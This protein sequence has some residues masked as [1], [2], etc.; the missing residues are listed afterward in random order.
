[1]RVYICPLHYRC[2]ESKDNKPP[3][4]ETV[5]DMDDDINKVIAKDI[6][7]AKVIINGK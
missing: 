1:L 2:S 6:E 5:Y 7:T 4:Q 3:D